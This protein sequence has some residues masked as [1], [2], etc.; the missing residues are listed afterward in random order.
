MDADGFAKHVMHGFSMCFP[1]PNVLSITE[2]PPKSHTH[3]H[4]YHLQKKSSAK[5][6]ERSHG[7]ESNSY[8]TILNL[9]SNYHG[10]NTHLAAAAGPLGSG[11]GS[12]SAAPSKAGH[13]MAEPKNVAH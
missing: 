8:K 4:F 7:D 12:E 11:H 10:G 9:T 6:I 1:T 13:R 2:T 3:T 5:C